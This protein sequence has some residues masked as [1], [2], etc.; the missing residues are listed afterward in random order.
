MSINDDLNSVL[1]DDRNED[2]EELGKEIGLSA[3]DIA[4]LKEI[5]R[6]ETAAA[7]T[8]GEGATFEQILKA[9]MSRNPDYRAQV[10]EEAKRLEAEETRVREASAASPMERLAGKWHITE[11]PYDVFYADRDSLESAKPCRE[12]PYLGRAP[13]YYD[14]SYR[15]FDDRVEALRSEYRYAT[16]VFNKELKD[17]FTLRERNY[18]KSA[19]EKS[20]DLEPGETW[21]QYLYANNLEIAEYRDPKTNDRLYINNCDMEIVSESL[22][23]Q[24]GLVKKGRR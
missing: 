1:N 9:G 5:D 13:Q 14:S 20:G 23:R 15:C 19:I 12:I 22:R 11:E 7:R 17:F 8:P 3:S 24:F 10:E 4:E 6:Q 18:L 21:L 2:L 16:E